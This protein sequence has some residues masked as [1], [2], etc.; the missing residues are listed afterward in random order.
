MLSAFAIY[1][2]TSLYLLFNPRIL[3]RKRTDENKRR[4]QRYAHISHRGGAAESYENTIGGFRQ[5]IEVQVWMRIV[6]LDLNQK[7]NPLFKQS[8]HQM[9]LSLW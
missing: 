9:A 2:T 4:F 5:G 8:S 6:G 3:H 1:V 7:I